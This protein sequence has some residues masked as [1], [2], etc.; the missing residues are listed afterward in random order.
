MS[1]TITALL[2]SS[3]QVTETYSTADSSNNTA[4]FNTLGE[5]SSYTA[6]TSVPV[7]KHAE[8]DLALSSGSAT[9]DLTALPGRTADETVVGTGLKLQILKLTNKSTNANK[10]SV[11]KGAST[12]YS[13][14]ANS[15]S[16]TVVLSPGQS[17]LFFLNESAPDVSSSVKVFDVTG[18]G[19]QVLQVQ[20][21]LG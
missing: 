1:S 7:A 4:T 10:I 12:G 9:I 18:T 3:I 2:Q 11:A 5:L 19:A 20:I 17:A 6:S 16:W 8:Y 14:D 21:V 13:L 15:T